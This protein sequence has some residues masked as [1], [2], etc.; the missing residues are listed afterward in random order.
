[1]KRKRHA[2]EQ[3]IS[4]LREADALLRASESVARVCSSGASVSELSTTG[5]PN[6]A[7]GRRQYGPFE[8]RNPGLSYD[9]PALHASC[10]CRRCG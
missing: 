1:M 2:P 10:G 4:S 7:S 3:I 5:S 8:C 6:T 9:S